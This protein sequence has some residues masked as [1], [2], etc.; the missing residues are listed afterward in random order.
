MVVGG[1]REDGR[2]PQ[3]AAL[4]TEET[5][6]EIADR[7]VYGDKRHKKLTRGNGE[8][9]ADNSV[10]DFAPKRARVIPLIPFGEIKLGTE[11]RDLIRNLIPRS[12]LIVAWGPPKCGKSFGAF[13]LCMHIALGWKYR[14]R[15][16]QQGPVVYCA[17]EGQNGISARVEAFRQHVLAENADANIP[18][19]LEPVTLSLARDHRALIA[20]IRQQLGAQNPVMVA[21]DTLNRSIEGSESSDQDMTRY[22]NA[23]DAIRA[24]FGCAVLIVHHCGI[25]GSRPRGH[26]SLTGAADAQLAVRRSESGIVTLTVEWMKDGGG[27]GD[28]IAFRLDRVVVGQDDDGEDITS[29]IVVP[30][31]ETVGQPEHRPKLSAKDELAR[32]ELATLLADE[33]QPA[34][35]TW[36]LPNGV[37]TVA[38]DAWRE[39]LVSRGVVPQ[40]EDRRRFWDLRDRLKV[41]GFAAER[42][43]QIWLVHS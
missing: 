23:A 37:V 34:P 15:R 43:H 29:C 14:G 18:F 27:E 8:P 39:R 42:D 9:A 25:D 3:R 40:V 32:R 19:F 2:N 36:G 17:F 21:L 31:D 10:I 20:S 33:G 11:R 30:V 16:V 22:V 1:R 7:L 26:T 35:T 38:V 4:M 41:K 6:E 13:D 5:P 28:V 24:A 12:G